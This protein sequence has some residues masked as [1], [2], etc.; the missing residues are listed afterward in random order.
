MVVE[1]IILMIDLLIDF[2]RNQNIKILAKTPR[3]IDIIERQKAIILPIDFR[4]LYLRVNGM[5]EFYPNEIDDEGFLFY[6]LAELVSVNTEFENSSMINK[7]KV[8]I[9]A[10]YMHRSWWYGFEVTGSN[11]YLIGII[12]DNTSFKPITNSLA[13]FIELYIENSPKLYDYS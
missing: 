4:E 11:E 10:E 9:F 2:W 5:E 3:E 13:E 1:R 6:P 12:S 8:F 7:E